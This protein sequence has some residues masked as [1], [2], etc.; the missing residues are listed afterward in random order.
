MT[1]KKKT[2]KPVPPQFAKSVAARMESGAQLREAIELAVESQNEP[3]SALEIAAIAGE[4][5]GRKLD[6]TY[7]GLLLRDM[8]DAGKIVARPETLEERKIRCEGR[9][10]TGRIG[11]LY[12]RAG[13]KFPTRKTAV[14]VPGVRLGLPSTKVTSYGKRGAKFRKVSTKSAPSDLATLIEQMIDERM[15]KTEKKLERIRA[16]LAE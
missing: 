9:P 12:F 11:N 7:V 16:I 3:V 13:V 1:A 10:L 5:V 15:R 2:K 14:L 6:A 8:I 4:L